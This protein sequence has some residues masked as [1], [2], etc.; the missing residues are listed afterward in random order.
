MGQVITQS[1]LLGNL[2]IVYYQL[3]ETVPAEQAKKKAI[4][5]MEQVMDS[6][7]NCQ[8][9]FEWAESLYGHGYYAESFVHLTC[10]HSMISDGESIS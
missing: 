3:E 7:G 1:V 4:I 5:L 9:L 2:A 6:Y 10:L 8:L